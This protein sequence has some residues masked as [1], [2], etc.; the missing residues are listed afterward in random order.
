MRILVVGSSR[1]LP[2]HEQA[3]RAAVRELGG[4]L[5][6]RGH[7]V[8][9]G[10]DHPDDVDPHVVEGAFEQDAKGRVEVHV[11]H[12]MPEPYSL[13]PLP[14]Q[15]QVERHQFP[16]WDITVM[17]VIRER[18]DAVIAFGGRLGVIQAGLSAWMLDRPVVPVGSFDGGA[19][20]IWEYSS[21]RRT[22]FYRGGLSDA[23]VDRLAGPWGARGSGPNAAFVVDAR[24]RVARAT[25]ISRT[26]RLLMVL[27]T[28][29]LLL[30]LG[31]WIAILTLSADPAGSV[32]L[33]AVFACVACAGVLGTMLQTTVV[34][35]AHDSNCIFSRHLRQR[36]A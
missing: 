6:R 29:M 21:A 27:I 25:A 26:P 30:A 24:D 32:D 34:T 3:L 31:G 19:K 18:V 15:V 5:V 35:L 11:P 16:N 4:E 14:G 28:A 7:V 9:I 17:E 20:T 33:L 22:Q 10:S 12:G 36:R 13:S 8:V 23:D 1:G 2:N